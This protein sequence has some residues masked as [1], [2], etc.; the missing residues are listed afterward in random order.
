MLVFAR[1][2]LGKCI[3][4][5]WRTW[6]REAVGITFRFRAGRLLRRTA[7]LPAGGWTVGRV[8]RGGRFVFGEV[9]GFVPIRGFVGVAYRFQFLCWL[10]RRI[11]LDSLLV[12]LL[13]FFLWL[14]NGMKKV[15]QL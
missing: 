7:L 4:C 11:V 5:R 1:V 14:L 15:L 3:E 8:V 2:R 9:G 10:V 6:H 13:D 12:V